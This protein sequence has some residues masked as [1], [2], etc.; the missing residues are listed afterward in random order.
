[1]PLIVETRE[2]TPGITVVEPVG[3]FEVYSASE[4]KAALATLTEPVG[5]RVALS[6]A[7]VTFLDSKGIG[8]IV[9]GTKA[10]RA[11]DGELAIICASERFRRHIGILRLDDFLCLVESDE[12]AVEAL[13]PAPGGGGEPDA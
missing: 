3:E 2:L 5:C 7:R 10:A 4:V 13:A 9:E 12:A 1:M 11:Q 8:V 6:L